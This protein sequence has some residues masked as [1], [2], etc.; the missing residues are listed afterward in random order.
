MAP[1][2]AEPPPLDSAGG[3]VG[4]LL[5]AAAA[6]PVTVTLVDDADLTLEL[7]VACFWVVFNSGISSDFA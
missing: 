1:S 6:E 3:C 4:E 7:V 5:A 2:G